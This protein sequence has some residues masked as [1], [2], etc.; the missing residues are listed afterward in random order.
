VTARADGII[1]IWKRIVGT[2]YLAVPHR[3]LLSGKITPALLLVQD[4]KLRRGDD[5]AAQQSST[6]NGR[7]PLRFVF[8]GL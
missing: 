3:V 8:L 1:I 5:C 7:H 2:W 4:D 6:R